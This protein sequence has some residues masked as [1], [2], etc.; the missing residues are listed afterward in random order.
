MCHG[1]TTT[2]IITD[3]GNSQWD[4]EWDYGGLSSEKARI[5]FGN[6]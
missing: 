3:A 1:I 4:N 2:T 5:T 6:G